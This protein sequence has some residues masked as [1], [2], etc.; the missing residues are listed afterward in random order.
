MAKESIE[1]V[2]ADLSGTVSLATAL[3]NEHH[4]IDAGIEAFLART[5]DAEGSVAEWA[6]PL[7]EAMRALRRH[8][9]LEEEIVFPRIR[10]G[11]LTM[12]V[13]VMLREHGEIRREMDALDDALA[14]GADTEAATADLVA[15]CRRMLDL[16]EQHNLKE[17]PVIYPHLDSDMDWV[18]QAQ[19]REFL[20]EGE[21]PEGWACERA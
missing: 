1:S 18:A 12:P 9:Y 13:M 7:L 19:L 8:I 21:L 17:E 20:R 2:G 6:E 10:R 14:H 15:G 3:T 16:L 5:G 11:P 4:A